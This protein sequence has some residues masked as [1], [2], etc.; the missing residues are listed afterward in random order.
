MM[1]RLRLLYPFLF[2]VLPILTVLTRNAGGSTLGDIA[3]R[4]G[5]RRRRPGSYR[6][7]NSW[8]Q[9]SRS[10]KTVTPLVEVTATRCFPSTMKVI[11]GPI[12]PLSSW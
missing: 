11:G 12:G 6:T 1:R 9:W 4:M 8:G 7:R 2:V 10:P 3:I 5:V